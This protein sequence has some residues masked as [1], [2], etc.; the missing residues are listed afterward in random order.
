MNDENVFAH[1]VIIEKGPV[2][3]IYVNSTFAHP[4]RAFM[5]GSARRKSHSVWA[6]NTSRVAFMPAA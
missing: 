4:L 1:Q 2:V 3:V 5:L 6:S